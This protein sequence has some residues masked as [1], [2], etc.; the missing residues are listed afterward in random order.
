MAK[1]IEFP[2]S[3]PSEKNKLE[4]FLKQPDEFWED[5]IDKLNPEECKLYEDTLKDIK[6]RA[7]SNPIKLVYGSGENLDISVL[8]K[9]EVA[10]IIYSRLFPQ[11]L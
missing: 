1:I 6:E 2:Q 8:T 11:Y 5:Q 10:K 4:Y 7:K 3:N 9:G